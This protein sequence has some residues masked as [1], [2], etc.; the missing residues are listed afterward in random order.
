MQSLSDL[1][2]INVDHQINVT[3][4]TDEQWP[5]VEFAPESEVPDGLRSMEKN[6][7][8]PS[9]V[10]VIKE[11][12]FVYLLEGGDKVGRFW[13]PYKWIFPSLTVPVN[14]FAIVLE[15]V[16]RVV[17]LGALFVY[18]GGFVTVFPA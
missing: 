16:P 10:R 18:G 15:E 14:Q 6:L 4:T 17:C 3:N 8:V 9:E 13:V 7:Q 2:V 1:G 5:I 12:I 11:P